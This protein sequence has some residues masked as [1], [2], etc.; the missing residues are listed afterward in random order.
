[1]IFLSEELDVPQSVAIRAKKGGQYYRSP[2]SYLVAS[3]IQCK[4]SG[5]DLSAS[6]QIM[7]KYGVCHRLCVVLRTGKIAKAF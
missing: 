4:L 2:A 7:P 3:M 6:T 5:R 1:M